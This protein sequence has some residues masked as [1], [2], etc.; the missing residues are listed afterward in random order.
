MTSN[1]QRASPEDIQN[2][3]IASALLDLVTTMR[4][5]P[6]CE[7]LRALDGVTLR[8]NAD[9]TVDPTPILLGAAA[10]AY[11]LL[12]A[13]GM[14]DLDADALLFDARRIIDGVGGSAAGVPL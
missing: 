4:D 9:T 3:R 7:V 1:G 8:V 6:R 12:A 10:A 14:H 5:E 11:A 13:A 2:A